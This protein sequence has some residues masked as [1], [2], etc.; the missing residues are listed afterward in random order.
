MSNIWINVPKNEQKVAN[1]GLC[2]RVLYENNNFECT[3][4]IIASNGS[5]ECTDDSKMLI[6]YWK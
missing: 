1:G 2:G 5:L 4:Y 6:D 3:H